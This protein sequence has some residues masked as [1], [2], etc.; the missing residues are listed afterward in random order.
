MPRTVAVALVAGD[1]LV[2][3][4]ARPVGIGV[5]DEALLKDRLD[6][7]AEGVVHNPVAERCCRNQPML[8]H[9]HLDLD[10]A[11]GPPSPRP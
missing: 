11:A 8:R 4:L 10:I 3:A 2:G 9:E 5:E 1:R 6:H 7:G